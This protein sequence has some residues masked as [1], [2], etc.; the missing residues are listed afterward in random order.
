MESE[1][2]VVEINITL[3]LLLKFGNLIDKV[4]FQQRQKSQEKILGFFDLFYL[5]GYVKKKTVLVFFFFYM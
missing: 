3:L 4:V 2:P 1:H 5:G